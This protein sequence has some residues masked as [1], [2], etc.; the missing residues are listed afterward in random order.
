MRFARV[1]RIEGGVNLQQ[2]G[3]P[4]KMWPVVHHMDTSLYA[5]PHRSTTATHASTGFPRLPNLP[6]LDIFDMGV[7]SAEC[8][9]RGDNVSE[10]ACVLMTATV[11]PAA[12]FSGYAR[13]RDQY[14]PDCAACEC[15]QLPLQWQDSTVR[16]SVQCFTPVPLW[17]VASAGGSAVCATVCW[18]TQVRCV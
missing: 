7:R 11:S 18:K 6:M 8:Q 14:R 9:G 17:T 1:S 5:A 16:L 4:A 12:G 2:D 3:S 15:V 10:S 13:L